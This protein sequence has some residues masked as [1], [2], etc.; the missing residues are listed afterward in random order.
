[1]SSFCGLDRCP[2]KL[3]TLEFPNIS[4]IHTDWLKSDTQAY[5]IPPVSSIWNKASYAE[6]EGSSFLSDG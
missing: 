5:V 2:Q 1:M 6:H 3:Q 4:K